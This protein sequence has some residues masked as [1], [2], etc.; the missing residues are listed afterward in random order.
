VTAIAIAA[1]VTVGLLG[2]DPLRSG[3][4]QP[5]SA[6]QV[7]H[8]LD[9]DWNK[10]ATRMETIAHNTRNPRLIIDRRR[11][12]VTGGTG[13]GAVA[14]VLTIKDTL[15]GRSGASLY[16]FTAKVVEQTKDPTSTAVPP[17]SS[18]NINFHGYVPSG[19]PF[20]K[21]IDTSG[22]NQAI[23]NNLAQPDPSGFSFS[24]DKSPDQ[25]WSLAVQSD[26]SISPK[27]PAPNNREEPIDPGAAT[28]LVNQISQD[29][30]YLLNASNLPP[31]SPLEPSVPS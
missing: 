9:S 11:T 4:R 13:I 10:L 17:L 12:D 5:L 18:F 19:L 8:D 2:P 27:M 29:I 20:K 15:Y 14:T 26:Y 28:S 24:M 30:D 22:G 7:N 3:D 21:L 23:N 16:G 31:G 6:E 25:S 1:G